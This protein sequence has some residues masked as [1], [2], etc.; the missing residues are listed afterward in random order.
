MPMQDYQREFLELVI[1]RNA[2]RFGRFELKSGRVSPYFFNLGALHTGAA[3]AGLG[4]A[5]AR[6]LVELDLDFEM[7]FGP[8][9]KGIPL[10]S[11]TAVALA[12]DHARDLPWCFDRKEAKDHGE[13]GNIVGA[14]LSGRVVVIDD[15]VTAGTAIRHA[16]DLIRSAGAEVAAVITALDRQERGAGERSAAAEAAAALAAPVRSIITLSDVLDYLDETGRHPESR[17]AIAA[18]RDRYGAVV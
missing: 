17:A 4:R 1:A 10:V 2:L 6:T 12:D 3:L 13:G 9:Y 7:L 8:A 15:V 11:A 14:P 18:Y 16:T 5:Y